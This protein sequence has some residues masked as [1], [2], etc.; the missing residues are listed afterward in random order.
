MRPLKLDMTAFGPYAEPTSVDFDSL[1][2]GIYLVSGDTGAGK[3][4]IFDAIVFALFGE[5]SGSSRKP[6]M[7]HSDFASKGTDTLVRLAFLHNGRDYIVE[8]TIHF[9]KV[10]GKTDEYNAKPTM[11]AVLREQDGR[12]TERSEAVTARVTELLGLNADQ[13][14]KIVML[15]QG[16]FRAFLEADN[17]TRG[18]ILGKLFN[19]RRHILFQEQ[20]RR[21]E[22]K[23]FKRRE[24][25][26]RVIGAL[27]LPDHFKLPEDA[28]E[29]ERA[30]YSPMHPQIVENL[31]ELVERDGRR[32]A[33]A[34]EDRQRRQAEM[35]KLRMERMQA[36]QGNAQL[37]A[38]EKAVGRRAEF[39]QHRAEKELLAQ[40]V[41]RAEGALHIVWPAVARRREKDAEIKNDRAKLADLKEKIHRQTQTA[42]ELALRHA[43]AAAQ[44]PQ[45]DA[46]VAQIAQ[47][48]RDLP[49]YD[50]LERERAQLEGSAEKL[51]RASAQLERANAKKNDAAAESARLEALIAM[52]GGAE[53]DVK[54]LE[55]KREEALA[56][57]K[58]IKDLLK[59]VQEQAE[60]DGE[61]EK[62]QAEL[63]R[64]TSD[65]VR[66]DE[67][68]S[69]LYGAFVE[70]QAALLGAKLAEDIQKTGE[71]FCPVCGTHFTGGETPA[72]I[73]AQRKVPTQQEVEDAKA[74]AER[75][76]KK[77][78][79][80][81]TECERRKTA[82]EEK[83]S[84][85]SKRAA[86]HGIESPQWDT[87]CSGEPI[88]KALAENIREGTKI[89]E[90]LE[91][92]RKDMRLLEKA[93][94]DLAKQREILAEAEHG[95]DEART[96]AEKHGNEKAAL[97]H[98]VRQRG[99]RLKFA[100][101]T[102]AQ[103]QLE[104]CQKEHAALLKEL[105]DAQ[106]ANDE[107]HGALRG[108]QG[109]MRSLERRIADGEEVLGRLEAE[110]IGAAAGA[111][112]ADEAAA[113]EA[114]API[115]GEDGER[116][117]RAAREELSRFV[118]EADRAAREEERLRGETQGIV[119]AD[120]DAIDE[121]LARRQRDLEEADAVYAAAHATLE[122]HR[123]TY[124]AVC[125]AKEKIS[126][127]DA[128]YGRL[129]K[130][131]DLAAG[132]AGDD[133]V[134]SFDRFA[135]TGFFRE[136]LEN[137]NM[138]L[139]VMSGGKYSLV[140][141]VEGGR[142]NSAAG[143][144]I[145]VQDA[146]T[147]EQRKTASLSGGESFQVS[148]ALALGLSGTVQSHAGGQRVDSMFIDEGFG[149]LDERVLD[150][151]I[152]VLDRLAGD[153]RQIGIISHVAKLEECIPQKIVVRSGKK[154][155]S[156]KIV[157]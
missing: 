107:A 155:S 44:Q 93:R 7:L 102:Q 70:G 32:A 143:L 90:R 71:A 97:E 123:E 133:V 24:D 77:R 145:E 92:A 67:R 125:R 89:A 60:A 29:E 37:D 40:A 55:A 137:A 13:F 63:N 128:A 75:A 105:N 14:R 141:M 109:E 129:R 111:G 115:G 38:L 86:E 65:A 101:K 116:W 28:G 87:I 76:E 99:Q 1:G 41:D 26:E 9:A 48:E 2:Q 130:L 39:E 98:S 4:T 74:E 153:S 151:A 121:R 135:M 43:Q 27:L 62:L 96:A 142:R 156:L 59:D 61:I 42:Q 52:H 104:L 5:A 152:Q 30:L 58:K 46:L 12:T 118:Q 33:A 15:A 91:Q 136:I 16:E 157:R 57:Y 72:C 83:R 124:E 94:V 73:H 120:L 49:E 146:F 154:G 144:N 11:N 134:Y 36:V 79:E 149:S 112:F 85:L 150:N 132:R 138:H 54:L 80:I 22:R 82:M 103:A 122:S 84:Q 18:E 3:T 140:H 64:R 81:F 53:A 45:M 19:N 25:A 10:R 20:L 34:L 108:M 56:V 8:R 147:G 68:R 50:A 119:R 95:A 114:L 106:A 126:G 100:A 148:M 88:R 6:E 110:V 131:A 139:S 117:I 69:A 127:S 78:L 35:D 47:I 17:N 51:G 31:R 21:A 113:L 66:K 23:L